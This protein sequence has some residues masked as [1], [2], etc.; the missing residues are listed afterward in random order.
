MCFPDA[1][2]LRAPTH[3]RAGDSLGSL[4]PSDTQ[5]SSFPLTPFRGKLTPDPSVPS[6]Q[7]RLFSPSAAALM[8]HA[9]THLAGLELRGDGGLDFILAAQAVTPLVGFS[10]F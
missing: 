1:G 9:Q 5:F 10:L 7:Q 6:N 4:A 3:G 2:V 8:L